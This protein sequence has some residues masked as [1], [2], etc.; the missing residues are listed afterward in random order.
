MPF[1]VCLLH[2]AFS[3]VRID[4]RQADL[5]S[6]AALKFPV[7]FEM[8]ERGE[9]HLSGIR[10]LA[11]HLTE[12]NHHAVLARAKHKSRRETEDLVAEI[13][14]TPDVASRFVTLPLRKPTTMTQQESKHDSAAVASQLEAQRQV[15]PSGNAA[16][17][18][19]DGVI[20][21]SP[22]RY[23]VQITVGQ[24]T[25]DKL[26]ELQ[27]LLSYQIP[28]AD[29][30]SIIDR[31]LSE[32]LAKARKQKAALTDKPRK[33]ARRSD[34]R[35]RSIPAAVQREVFRRDNGQ[36]RFVDEA[37]NRCTTK[38]FIEFHN[39]RPLRAWRSSRRRQHRAS[40]PGP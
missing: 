1:D 22:R 18:K 29:P 11:K 20:P 27:E 31:A 14:P 24:E 37:G 7:L 13:A 6:K 9:I 2:P 28:S 3:H 34:E 8:V 30:A 4:G 23:K 5:G 21:L 33:G 40:V 12:E 26:R 32:L 17:R 15:A 25:H 39:R 38:R 16:A 19:R 35:T 10:A 36:C